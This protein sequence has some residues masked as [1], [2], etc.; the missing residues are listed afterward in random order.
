MKQDRNL[1][2]NDPAKDHNY[3]LTEN[4]W[5]S[6]HILLFS[7]PFLLGFTHADTHTPVIVPRDK[8]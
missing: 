7:A 2:R 8:N 4:G 5:K 6:L 1:K 3:I